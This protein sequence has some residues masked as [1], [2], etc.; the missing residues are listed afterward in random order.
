MRSAGVFA[1]MYER[2]SGGRKQPDRYM[3]MRG[4]E[5]QY[6]ACRRAFD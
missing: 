3:D 2:L 5:R 4:I 1:F 6:V